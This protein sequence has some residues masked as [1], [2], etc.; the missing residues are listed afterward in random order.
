MAFGE[1]SGFK[2]KKVVAFK[3]VSDDKIK[4]I[5]FDAHKRK[6]FITGFHRR[7]DDRREVAKQQAIKKEKDDIKEQKR[8]KK[9]QEEALY[10]N[11]LAGLGQSLTGSDDEQEESESSE[12]EDDEQE[13]K[14]VKLGA[15][16]EE[17]KVDE[18]GD[19]I[20]SGK[21]II[22]KKTK[23]YENESSVITTIVT[24][25]SFNSDGEEEEEGQDG[26]GDDDDEDEEEDG[27]NN[28]DNKKKND[29]EKKGK[30]RKKRST[31]I[32]Q[33]NS[34]REVVDAK[35]KIFLDDQG[36]KVMMRKIKGKILPI[37]MSERAQE[38]VEHG[39]KLPRPLRI[40]HKKSWNPLKK[41]T[42]KK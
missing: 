8:L 17:E 12:S 16:E 21:G 26:S 13:T 38:A 23:E 5:K 15:S 30:K 28:G 41:K 25:L 19:E 20:N 1:K 22:Q 10:N 7:K 18:N 29:G 42:P 9:V 31:N 11:Y 36:R 14:R 35:K 37:V 32:V 40:H 2:K 34:I 24:P 6:D 39:W 3:P 4:E 27:E 33:A